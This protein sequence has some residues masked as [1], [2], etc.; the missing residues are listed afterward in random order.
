MCL[1]IYKLDPAKFLSVPGL[2]WQAALKQTK[3]KL[4]LLTDTDMLLMVEK[5]VRGE[6]CHS[7]NKFVKANKKYM[8]DYDINKELSYLK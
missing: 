8:K 3:V 6:I 7:I 5:E 2:A 1:G 4:E